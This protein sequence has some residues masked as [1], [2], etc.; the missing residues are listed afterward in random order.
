MNCYIELLNSLKRGVISPVYLF[1]GE[2]GYLREQAI[3]HFKE[4]F[5]QM[6]G[7]G[8][9][10]D[11]I[12]GETASPAEVAAKADTLP[13]MS[14]KR[15]V[16][17]NNTT[18]FKGSKKSVEDEEFRDE[19]KTADE[20]PLLYYLKEPLPSTCLVFN[21]GNQV[22][23]R[24]RIYK[25]IAKCG[26]ALEF[27][28]LSRGE[29]ARWLSQRAG[30]AGKR[31]AAGAGEALLDAAGPFLQNLTVELEK[32]FNYTSGQQVISLEDVRKVCP[33]QLEENIFAVVDAIGARKFGEAMSGIKDML[34][35]KEPPLKILTMIS[36]QFRL[37][38]QAHELLGRGRL[39]TDV[40][41]ELNVHPYVAQKITSQ[42]KNFK[43]SA[44][45]DAIIALSEIDIA[46][47][48]GRQEFLPALEVFLLKLATNSTG[49][50]KNSFH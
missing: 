23:K 15:L 44:L 24:K 26:R 48:S 17:V 5:Y 21:T 25:A 49:G 45:V 31:F 36:R 3:N 35:A 42:C 10:I 19:A 46:L 22:D 13:F 29:L 34:A 20:L 8:L 43:S 16:V 41:H 18:F 12:D 28:K 4:Y 6:D 2:E 11:I 1:F 14:G 38:L 9:N 33:Q 27:T 47:K 40:S 7:S 30:K 39:A 32:L 37:L 50:Y